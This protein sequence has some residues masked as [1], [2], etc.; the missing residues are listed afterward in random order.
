MSNKPSPIEFLQQELDKNKVIEVI[1]L[2]IAERMFQDIVKESENREKLLSSAVQALDKYLNAGTKEERKSASKHAKR[3]YEEYHK[4]P[5]QNKME[6][7]QSNTIADVTDVHLNLSFDD[8]VL[9][10]SEQQA[11]QL[12]KDLKAINH[13]GAERIH[14]HI[15]MNCTFPCTVH[16]KKGIPAEAAVVEGIG[17]HTKTYITV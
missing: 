1:D 14:A 5:Y 11:N 16:I 12:L 15:L 3:V 10:Y 4:V 2:N 8:V 17:N 6:R 7:I 13:K 9:L